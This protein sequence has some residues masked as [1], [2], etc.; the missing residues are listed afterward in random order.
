MKEMQ[1]QVQVPL[2]TL[3]INLVLIGNQTYGRLVFVQ[4]RPLIGA[5]FDLDEHDNIHAAFYEDRFEFFG[6]AD[7]DGDEVFEYDTIYDY[8][9]IPLML[10]WL[11]Q[12]N[13]QQPK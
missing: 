5:V 4:V 7:G 11:Q 3:P 9:N 2:G 10:R 1:Y 12:Q 6:T 13:L 8:K